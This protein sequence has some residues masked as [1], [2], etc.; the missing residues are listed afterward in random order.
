MVFNNELSLF[1]AYLN[2]R[3][4][5]GAVS[6]GEVRCD[7]KQLRMMQQ[8]VIKRIPRWM[9][10][11][12]SHLWYGV[13]WLGS[14]EVRWYVFFAKFECP[15]LYLAVLQCKSNL[16][17]AIERVEWTPRHWTYPWGILPCLPGYVY[18]VHCVGGIRSPIM[19]MEY[20]EQLVS[21]VVFNRERCSFWKEEIQG[22]R[23]TS[24]S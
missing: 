20:T 19:R 8:G 21:F 11:A 3:I 1:Y 10:C 7:V 9:Q 22:I 14:S 4:L 18:S 15:V 24:L 17:V 6:W 16:F 12:V 13:K 23:Y 2:C 5:E